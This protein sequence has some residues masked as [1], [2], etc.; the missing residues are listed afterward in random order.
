[1]TNGTLHIVEIP[2]PS[3]SIKCRYAFVLSPDGSKRIRHGRYVEYHPDGTVASE[4]NYAHDLEEGEWRDYHPNGQLAAVGT[5]VSGKEEGAWRF[6]D[7]R[8]RPE[9][10]VVY[11][12]GEQK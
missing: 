7:E 3:G 12:C 8:G 5:Y 9:P 2:F 10:E 1:V 4:G 11:R 6:W